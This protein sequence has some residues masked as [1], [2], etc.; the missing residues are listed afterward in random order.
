MNVLD[1]SKLHPLKHVP[2]LY[3]PFTFI[4][5]NGTHQSNL[6]P[7]NLDFSLSIKSHIQFVSKSCWFCLQIHN[8]NL[9]ITYPDFVKLFLLVPI[10]TLHSFHWSTYDPK[11]DL[12]H[13]LQDS[14]WFTYFLSSSLLSFIFMFKRIMEQFCFKSSIF[15][16]CCKLYSLQLF[17]LKND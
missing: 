15:A 9:P 1:I 8:P 3:L 11:N 6:K 12:H 13:D 7:D 17:K 16:I 5:V 10:P 4:P 14:E 2:T